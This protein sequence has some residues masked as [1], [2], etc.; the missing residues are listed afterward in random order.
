MDQ[1]Y[2]WIIIL[3]IVILIL[4]FSE[5]FFKKKKETVKENF[6]N[7]WSEG[8]HV[9]YY[10]ENNLVQYEPPYS[11]NAVNLKLNGQY[12]SHAQFSNFGTNG[13]EPPYLKCPKCS[14]QFNCSNYPYEVD[15]KNAN[16]C[17][18][19]LERIYYNDKNEK[20]FARAN[21]RPR[22]CRK[23]ISKLGDMNGRDGKVPLWGT[24]A[25]RL[26]L[27]QSLEKTRDSDENINSEE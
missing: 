13:I 15:D 4:D 5:R 9:P 25:S 20:V 19:C 11:T 23:I 8:L 22:Q 24:D 26:S 3:F 17:S 2:V 6:G 18:N 27:L 14:L 21:G 7:R 16:V 12:A 1:I 10:E